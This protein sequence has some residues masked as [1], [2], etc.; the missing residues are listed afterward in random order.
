MRKSIHL[1]AAG[2]AAGFLTIWIV[3]AIQQGGFW[4]EARPVAERLGWAPALLLFLSLVCWL[5]SGALGFL[6]T[7]G[8]S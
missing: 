8:K 2:L 1:I 7:E 3:Q 5:A 4:M 6:D